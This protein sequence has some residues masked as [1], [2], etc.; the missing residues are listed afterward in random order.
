MSELEKFVFFDDAG[1]EAENAISLAELETTRREQKKAKPDLIEELIE[2]VEPND[3]ATLIYTSGT[4]GEPKGVMLTHANIVSNVIDAGEK[5]SFDK[6]T[7]RFRFCRS[8]TFSSAG[9]VSLYF[10]RNGVFY[11][12][13]IERAPENLQEVRP[14][15]FVGVPRIFEKVYARAKM[16]A[17]QS[18]RSEGKN[19]R[20]GD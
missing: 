4:T 14:T 5:Y 6:T 11:A 17:A 15:I 18:K 10:Q 16:K 20:L 3:I 19:L 12:E 13:S 9:D 8:R 1:I 7:N 2:G